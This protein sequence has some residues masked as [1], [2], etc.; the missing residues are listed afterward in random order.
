MLTNFK[1][2]GNVLVIDCEQI[3]GIAF[4]N[5]LSTNL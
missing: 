5:M 1:M 3:Y 2:F 4:R